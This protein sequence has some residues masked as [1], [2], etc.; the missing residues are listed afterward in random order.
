[1]P[2]REKHIKSWDGNFSLGLQ[3]SFPFVK[4]ETNFRRRKK[5]IIFGHLNLALQSNFQL[6]TLLTF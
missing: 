3:C 4:A 6:E 2:K 1:M 5:V